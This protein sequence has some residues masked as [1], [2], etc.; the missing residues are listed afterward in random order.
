MA[1]TVRGRSATTNYPPLL[2]AGTVMLLLLAVMPSALNL[3]QS[4]PA[5]T[6]EYAPIPPEDNQITPPVGNL[7]SLG[8][9]STSSFGSSPGGQPGTPPLD[10][11]GKG[12]GKNPRVKNCVGDPPRQSEDPLAPPCVAFYDGDNGGATWNG[13]TRDEI[14]VLFYIQGGFIDC[15]TREGCEERPVSSYFDL[16]EPPQEDDNFHV[17][18]LRIWQRYF[19]ER[20]QTYNRR[21]HFFVYFNDGTT[22]VEGRRADAVENLERVKPFAVQ[23][24]ADV[25]D[26]YIEVM[27]RRGIMNFGSFENRP[28]SF[29]SRFPK[30]IWSYLPSIEQ[31]AAMYG[32]WVC[33]QIV[34]RPV[35]FSGN[36]GDQGKP[37]K[38]GFLSTAD[39]DFPGMQLFAQAAK[40]EIE[41]CGGQFVAEATAPYASWA[42]DTRTAGEEAT[43]NVARFIQAGVTTVIWAQGYETNHSKAAAQQNWRPE[44]VV[45]GD[46]FHEGVQTGARQEPT[47]WDYAWV[48]TNVVRSGLVTES[49]CYSALRRDP[50]SDPTDASFD[51][52]LHTYYQ[53]LR[54]LFTGI[55][56]AGPNLNP[57]TLDR[58]MRAIPAIRSQDPR[59]PACFYN[60]GDYTCVKDAMV[61]WWDSESQAPG[62]SEQGCWRMVEEGRRYFAGAWP[63]REASAGRT[64]SDPCNTYAG[65]LLLYV[66][67]A[68]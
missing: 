23:T 39:P 15:V 58:G 62:R 6:L 14:R 57:T 3:P 55:Q 7:S 5:E 47:V 54:Q 63:N 33:T 64:E 22:T 28:A 40:R 1:V 42:Q 11:P 2:L 17:R 66:G 4:S 41:K 13:V 20:Y 27:A 37:R 35:S 46:G 49:Q 34:D 25:P 52:G 38:L 56:V 30:L 32:S 68:D 36:A 18:Q 21:A 60:P 29:F 24:Y 43:Q 48:M 8:L 61:N 45:A 44:W 53:D 31:S 10:A 65:P 51:C 12:V 67:T 50:D 16:D 59:V 9:G 26:P 19:N